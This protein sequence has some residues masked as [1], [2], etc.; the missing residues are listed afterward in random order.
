MKKSVSIPLFAAIIVALTFTACKKYPDGPMLSFRSKTDRLCNTWQVQSATINGADST[1]IYSSMNYTI[2]FTTNNLVNE[3]YMGISGN[4]GTW[5]FDSKK[6]NILLTESGTVS[7]L[8]I[9]KL[10]KSA[11]WLQETDN[12]YTEVLHLIPY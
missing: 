1:S 6:E 12:G 3:S 8:E 10:E 2:Q 7:T 11:L 5:A 9:L 4:V